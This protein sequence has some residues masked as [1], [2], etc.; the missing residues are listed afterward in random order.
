[1]HEIFHQAKFLK[2]FETAQN[3]LFGCV[4]KFPSYV[5]FPHHNHHKPTTYGTKEDPEY[6]DVWIGKS[7]A[8]FFPI[9]P[10]SLLMPWFLTVRFGLLPFLYPLIGKKLRHL[11]YQRIST[12]AMNVA[13]IRALPNKE[14]FKNW[15]TQDYL[16]C[17]FN[18]GVMFL[19]FTQRLSLENFITFQLFGT[20]FFFSNFF[21][22]IVAHRYVVD[23]TAKTMVAQIED[24]ISF[25]S[26]V[27]DFFWAPVGLKYHSIHHYFPTIPYHNLKKA[28]ELLKAAGDDLYL[29]TIE[30]SYSGALRKAASGENIKKIP[31]KIFSKTTKEVA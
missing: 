13:Y 11:I 16:T 9:V 26:S 14:E 30:P 8:H 21:R 17:A 23:K 27:T 1:M 28:H 22:A 19:L 10:M 24:S 7:F 5:T 4:F 12:F 18:T 31:E 20:T 15:M 3:L 2:G 29:Q 6:D 25:P